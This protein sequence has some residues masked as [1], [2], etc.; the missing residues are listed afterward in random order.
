ML[1]W[2]TTV[3]AEVS[4]VSARAKKVVCIVVLVLF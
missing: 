2:E 1:F 3:T 4:E